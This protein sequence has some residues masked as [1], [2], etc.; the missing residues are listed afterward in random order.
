[1]KILWLCNIIPSLV[2]EKLGVESPVGGGWISGGLEG[3]CGEGDIEVAVCFPQSM[4]KEL[5]IGEVKRITYYGFPCSKKSDERYDVQIEGWMQ[6][7]IES[8]QPDL[9]HVW[10]T[11]FA[12]SLA[13]ARV[14]KKPERMICSIQGICASIA[15]HYRANLPKS[16]VHGWTLR[17]I[18]KH[19]NVYRREQKFWKRAKMEKQTVEMVSNVIGRTAFDKACTKMINGKLTYFHCD[20]TLRETFY[21]CQ[22]Q[23]EYGKCEKHSIFV[24]SASYPLKGFHNVLR[25]MPMILERFPDTQVYVIGNDPRK[26]PFYR[27]SKYYQYVKRLMSEFN[28][29]EKV[30]Y[31]GWLNEQ[32]MCKQFLQSNVFV[33]ASSVENSSNS[34]GEAMMLGMPVVASYVGG[35][36]DLLRD[37]SEGYLYQSDAP[38]MLAEYVCRMFELENMAKELGTNAYQH[39]MQIYDKQKNKERLKQIYREVFESVKG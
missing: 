38:Y 10:G 29:G 3:F 21:A 7:V 36:M 9:V 23:W 34:I 2:A 14:W 13:M 25:A 5:L 27:M 11:E 4:S 15:E 18:V 22:N 24:S 37:K 28:L 19:D 35:T 31:L 16:V 39:A 26:M 30:S 12:H 1:M 33:S 20:E 32:D 8:Y 17:D 6:R